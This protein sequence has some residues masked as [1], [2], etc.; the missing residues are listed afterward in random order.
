MGWYKLPLVLLF[1]WG[2]EKARYTAKSPS[3][4]FSRIIRNASHNKQASAALGRLMTNCIIY[5]I[6]QDSSV[7]RE[8]VI[9]SSQPLDRYVHYN[10][11]ISGSSHNPKTNYNAKRIVWCDLDLTL[12][13]VDEKKIIIES[14][15]K[16]SKTKTVVVFNWIAIQCSAVHAS[17]LPPIPT[18]TDDG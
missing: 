1:F 14:E 15:G 13:L 4:S 2:R 3:L 17:K 12:P 16:T 11:F 18:P 9:F 7:A 10:Y 8:R 6:W 5:P